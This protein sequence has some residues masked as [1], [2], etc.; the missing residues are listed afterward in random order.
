MSLFG[1][2]RDISLFRHINKELLN[3]IIQ[4]EVDF[5]K[6]DLYQTKTNI[7]GEAPRNKTYYTPVRLAAL[8]TRNDIVNT[9][10]DYTID[11]NQT[12]Q[13][14]FLR[15]GILDEMNLVPEIG[16]I[17]NWNEQYWELDSI[18]INQFI[19]GKNDSTNKTIGSQFGSNWSYICQTHLT[20]IDRT[21]LEIKNFGNN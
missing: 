17:I 15:D 7:Y 6:L 9:T 19:A 10:D 5:Y 2:A 11:T 8:I 18:N 12:V 14:A 4:T 20:R 1:S 3:N 16:D 13:F 21:K